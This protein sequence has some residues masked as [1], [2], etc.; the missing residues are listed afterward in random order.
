MALPHSWRFV[1][2]AELQQDSTNELA[3]LVGTFVSAD[4]STTVYVE[5]MNL[6]YSSSILAERIQNL[7]LERHC[8]SVVDS[9]LGV[10]WQIAEFIDQP[11]WKEAPVEYRFTARVTAV[12]GDRSAAGEDVV[13]R[14]LYRR[15]SGVDIRVHSFSKASMYA[16]ASPAIDSIFLGARPVVAEAEEPVEPAKTSTRTE[17]EA[18]TATGIIVGVIAISLVAGVV[19]W[20]VLARRR[21]R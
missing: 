20:R 10:D 2:S 17:G 6:T 1:T 16:A 21:R 9:I 15:V 18:A 7:G 12:S 4:S 14:Y 13:M 11:S 3:T 19:T 8:E 5:R